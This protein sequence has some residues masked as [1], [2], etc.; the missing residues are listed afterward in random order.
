M[1]GK[2]ILDLLHYICKYHV[3]VFIVYFRQY[4][5]YDM[6]QMLSKQHSALMRS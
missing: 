6:I 5:Y 2:G 4:N 3:K 1:H